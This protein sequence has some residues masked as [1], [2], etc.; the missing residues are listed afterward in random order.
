MVPTPVGPVPL[1]GPFSLEYGNVPGPGAGWI[2]KATEDDGSSQR[3]SEINTSPL[4]LFKAFL[5]GEN[6]ELGIF[7]DGLPSFK[8]KVLDRPGSF[9]WDFKRLGS[10]SFNHVLKIPAPG[11]FPYSDDSV[12][13]IESELAIDMSKYGDDIA[14]VLDYVSNRFERESK[15]PNEV[16]SSLATQDLRDKIPELD[17]EHIE[18]YLK[19]TA[20]HRIVLDII[21]ACHNELHFRLDPNAVANWRLEPKSDTK[22]QTQTTLLDLEDLKKVTKQNFENFEV[23]ENEGISEN[24]QKAI[25]G[26]SVEAIVRLHVVEMFLKTLPVYD[27]FNKNDI[28]SDEYIKYLMIK[29]QETC[30]KQD[31]YAP[32]YF[33]SILKEVKKIYEENWNSNNKK[34]IDPQTGNVLP[35]PSEAEHLGPLNYFIKKTVLNASS[36]LRSLKIFPPGNP[37]SIYKIFLRNMMAIPNEDIFDVPTVDDREMP[38]EIEGLFSESIPIPPENYKFIYKDRFQTLLI[39][40]VFS[41]VPV[42]VVTELTVTEELRDGL[43]TFSHGGLLLE[44]YIQYDVTEEI[45]IVD[46]ETLFETVEEETKTKIISLEEKSTILDIDLEENTLTVSN[47]KIGMRL[48]YVHELVSAE[49][50]DLINHTE[51]FES[52]DITESVWEIADN[53]RSFRILERAVKNYDGDSE[54]VATHHWTYPLPL[55]SVTVDAPNLDDIDFPKEKLID[56]MVESDRFKLLFEHCFPLQKILSIMTI[57][58][59]VIFSSTG[60]DRMANLFSQTKDTLKTIFESAKNMNNFSYR[61]KNTESVG[62]NSGLYRGIRDGHFQGIRKM[63]PEGRSRVSYDNESASFVYNNETKRRP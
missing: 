28:I 52:E 39:E 57:Y 51:G 26:A 23:G 48:V 27:M 14:D 24:L 55:V 11:F 54:Q 62:G 60:G 10:K 46:E 29:I 5:E 58:T 40:E 6:F 1:P 44:K 37:D 32:G 63:F 25:V 33:E 15:N 38:L 3:L 50:E 7:E 18:D 31:P 45:L 9:E 12:L 30:M 8:L 36:T 19:N 2:D 42:P 16:F 49:N 59:E 21:M 20:Y 34:L 22:G 43:G 4:G 47:I 35:S 13:R 41:D 53:S 17:T 56:K 61:D